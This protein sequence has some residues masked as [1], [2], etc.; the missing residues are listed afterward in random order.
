MTRSASK[1]RVQIIQKYE[2][3]DSISGLHFRVTH[4]EVVDHIKEVLAEEC[5]S[6]R[7]LKGALPLDQ[8][9]PQIIL[10]NREMTSDKV[11]TVSIKID[12]VSV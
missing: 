12:K 5:D 6:E 3:C 7:S 4:S 1:W 10:K 2:G 11:K 8:W 9:I